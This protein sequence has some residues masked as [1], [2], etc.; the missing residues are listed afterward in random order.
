MDKEIL[1]TLGFEKEVKNVEKGIC[2]FC[3]EE[4]DES[5]LKD[6]VSKREFKI[7]GIC[8][9]CQDSTFD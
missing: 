2:P 3:N 6:E 8:Q 9:K 1:R 4:V 7:S 5:K